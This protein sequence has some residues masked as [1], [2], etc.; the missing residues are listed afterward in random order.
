[1]LA[2]LSA[3]DEAAEKVYGA[4]ADLCADI[5]VEADS[6]EIDELLRHVDIES[7]IES[8]IRRA[9]REDDYRESNRESRRLFG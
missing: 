2:A 6:Y 7:I 9:S 1:M 5:G 3:T 8:N 4:I